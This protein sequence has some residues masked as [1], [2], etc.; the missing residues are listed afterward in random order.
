M[1]GLTP[2]DLVAPER[3]SIMSR[4]IVSLGLPLAAA[5]LMAAAAAAGARQQPTGDPFTTAIMKIRDGLYVIPGY[6]GAATG[7]NVAVRVTTEGV[8]VVDS[9]LPA[10]YSDI[11]GQ[12]RRVTPLPIRYVLSTHQHG[13]HTGSNA[14]FLKTAEI[15]MHRNARANMITQNLPGPG[16]IVYDSRQSVF[17]GGVEVQMHYLGRGHTNGDSVIY[18]EDLRTIHTGDLVLWGK[19]SQGTTLTPFMDYAAGNGS[20]REWVATL[21]NIL[22]LDFDAAIPGHGPVLTKEQVR[23]FRDKMHTLN[24]RMAE[25]VRSGGTKQDIAARI[26]LDDL[27]W[28]FAPGALDG[29]FD[30][31]SGR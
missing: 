19:R 30:E 23:A 9:K 14:E 22:K 25:L 4:T 13:D 17:L 31:L 7:G 16:R 6:D 2:G 3:K 21:D 12:V 29:L 11:V 5:I 10:L 24:E 1:T 26:R 27:D 28:P 20:G 15:L 18:F 8:I